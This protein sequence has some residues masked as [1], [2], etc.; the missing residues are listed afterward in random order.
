[1]AYLRHLAENATPSIVMVKICINLWGMAG[2][3]AILS[4]SKRMMGSE[5]AG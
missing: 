3:S 4:T 5:F 2:S 1:L